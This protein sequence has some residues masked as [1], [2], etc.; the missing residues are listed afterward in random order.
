[1]AYRKTDP[2]IC[3]SRSG[4]RRTHSQQIKRSIQCRRHF[5]YANFAQAT[6]IVGKR[7]RYRHP[8]DFTGGN[9][10]GV[11]IQIAF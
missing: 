1:V 8:E 2:A 7:P 9:L 4:L 11:C 6:R 3:K 10:P 5:R